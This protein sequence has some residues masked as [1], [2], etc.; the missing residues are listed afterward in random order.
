[1]AVDAACAPDVAGVVTLKGLDTGH[2][3]VLVRL[4]LG[5]LVLVELVREGTRLL[6]LLVL[7][8]LDRGRLERALLGRWSDG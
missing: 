8:L 5:A 6:V 2:V 4:V 1:M 7:A 3:L